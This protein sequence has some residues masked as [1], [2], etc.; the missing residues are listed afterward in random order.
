MF[1]NLYLVA[2]AAL[3]G[4]SAC[5]RQQV[6]GFQRTHTEAFARTE[7]V[8]QPALAVQAA[9]ATSTEALQPVENQAVAVEPVVST[10]SPELVASTDK[11][12][13]AAKGTRFEERALRMKAAI[14]NAS[15]KGQLNAAPRKLTFAEK[16]VAKMVAKKL[17]KKIAKAERGESTKALDKNLKLALIFAIAAIVLSLIPGVWYLGGIA[18]IVAVIFFVLWIIDRAG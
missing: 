13:A 17:N 12:V 8:A 11:L 4:L 15:A 6:G 7:S 3:C 2:L 16:T 18:G 5:Q 14:E 10:A 9:Q 1:K